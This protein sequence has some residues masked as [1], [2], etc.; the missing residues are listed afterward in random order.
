[1]SSILNDETFNDT[2]KVKA[3]HSLVEIE[4]MNLKNIL[5]QKSIIE[6]ENLS[7]LTKISKNYT[8]SLSWGKKRLC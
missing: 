1:M 6:A 3:M 8:G 4:K 5:E 7:Y 2:N